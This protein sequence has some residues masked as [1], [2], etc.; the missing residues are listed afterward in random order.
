M[1]YY[2]LFVRNKMTHLLIEF[3]SSIV[4]QMIPSISDALH[5][6]SSLISSEKGSP[7]VSISDYEDLIV[8]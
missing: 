2:I 1:N 4:E 3:G 5:Y 8:H 7:I 6:C